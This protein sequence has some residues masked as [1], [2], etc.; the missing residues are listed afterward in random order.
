MAEQRV[1]IIGNNFRERME[2]TRSLEDIGYKVDSIQDGSNAISSID[3]NKAANKLGSDINN[4]GKDKDYLLIIADIDTP[5]FSPLNFLKKS[6]DIKPFTEIIFISE[7]P[8]VEEA[9][10]LMKHGAFDFF[11]KPISF[12]QVELSLKRLL[13]KRKTSQH[14]NDNIGNQDNE[15]NRDGGVKGDRGTK[16][17]NNKPSASVEIIT[18]D[19]GMQRL[20][21]M[22]KRV[23]DSTASVLI[24]GES[25]TGKELV[26]RFIHQNSKRSNMPFV[27]LNCA[28]LPENLLESELFGHE[29]GAFTG[30]ITRKEGKF[31]LANNGTL[32]LDEITEMQYHLQAKL[33]RVVQEKTVDRLGGREPVEVDVR[34]V[35][36]TNRDIKESIQN[37]EFRE[38]LY[39]R[40]NTIPLTI[41]PLRQRTGDLKLLC[42]YFIKKYSIIDAR[43]VKGMTPEAYRL[44]SLQKFTGNVRELQNM[45]HRAV[46]LAEGELIEPQDLLMEDMPDDNIEDININDLNETLQDIP[47]HGKNIEELLESGSLR[48]IEEKVIY[49]TLDRTDGNR[50]HAAKLLGISV[51]TL[52]NKL[53]EYKEKK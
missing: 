15:L 21:N 39:H 35:A 37:G 28:A 2:M 20:L 17:S 48:D 46:L 50:T 51:R 53:N 10:T 32:F 52:R 9:V 6:K 8:L 41:P 40:L 13:S 49:S 26:A 23:A 4:I 12:E 1:L 36:S 31:E 47:K 11:I 27:A 34:I 42:D 29:K 43:D 25:G 38:D 44:L 14:K 5:A 45:I 3:N 30:A 22:A 7:R 33:L 16:N 24:Q 19:R 18:A